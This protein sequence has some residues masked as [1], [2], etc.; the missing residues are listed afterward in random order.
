MTGIFL[1]WALDK[2]PEV[3]LMLEKFPESQEPSTKDTNSDRPDNPIASCSRALWVY[4]EHYPEVKT[5]SECFDQL[6]LDRKEIWND[7]HLR[8]SSSAKNHQRRGSPYPNKSSTRLASNKIS[9]RRQNSP[10]RENARTKQP[11]V[12]FISPLVNAIHGAIHDPDRRSQDV[13]E[14]GPNLTRLLQQNHGLDEINSSPSGNLA[15]DIEHSDPRIACHFNYEELDMV[16][17]VMPVKDSM[18]VKTED[19]LADEGGFQEDSQSSHTLSRS[20]FRTD[21][22]SEET[23]EMYPDFNYNL[24]D[25]DRQIFS[26]CDNQRHDSST[27]RDPNDYF[28]SQTSKF[29]APKTSNE[30]FFT[31]CRPISNYQGYPSEPYLELDQLDSAFQNPSST[32]LDE[33]EFAA[34]GYPSTPSAQ[35]NY[36]SSL[37]WGNHQ[38]YNH[39]SNS[40]SHEIK[41]SFIQ[42]VPPFSSS[43]AISRN[44]GDEYQSASNRPD[45]SCSTR[46]ASNTHESS[47]SLYPQSQDSRNENCME[48]VDR[49]ADNNEQEESGKQVYSSTETVSRPHSTQGNALLMSF[50]TL[51]AAS[52]SSQHPFLGGMGDVSFWNALQDAAATEQA[53]ERGGEDENRVYDSSQQY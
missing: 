13:N 52:Q 1:L 24:S 31:Q 25:R 53:S 4:A 29:Q 10:M 34:L 32:T 18:V 33:A 15:L 36:T 51:F 6:V 35:M 9:S 12:R 14:S 3:I 43:H 21:T 22:P 49:S 39:E 11:G 27:E 20:Q 30:G 45:S 26:A 5:Y 44:L 8:R 47:T 17:C 46:A 16:E 19:H 28:T 41:E 23:R 37:L 48:G 42:M 2:D 7:S 50:N 40:G 38:G